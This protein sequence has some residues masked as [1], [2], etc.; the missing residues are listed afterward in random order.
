[1]ITFNVDP[2]DPKFALARAAKE[3]YHEKMKVFSTVIL[4]MLS[5]ILDDLESHPFTKT[6]TVLHPDYFIPFGD[7]SLYYQAN[8]NKYTVG[9]IDVEPKKHIGGNFKIERRINIDTKNTK[10]G[11]KD[12]I[13]LRNVSIC[14]SPCLPPMIWMTLALEKTCLRFLN[15]E[16]YADGVNKAIDELAAAVANAIPDPEWITEFDKNLGS[17]EL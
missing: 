15:E 17:G 4:R 1:M 13:S 5:S 7:Q 11:S 14:L 8:L 9:V 3:A 6:N 2:I 12:Q 10:K 16:S